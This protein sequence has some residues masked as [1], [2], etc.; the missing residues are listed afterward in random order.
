MIRHTQTL[1][2][3]FE[4]VES[5]KKGHYEHFIGPFTVPTFVA[6]TCYHW[7]YHKANQVLLKFREMWRGPTTDTRLMYLG[8]YS[9]HEFNP[10]VITVVMLNRMMV[11]LPLLANFIEYGRQQLRNGV[12]SKRYTVNPGI[13]M[14]T[15]QLITDDSR[16]D[17][18]FQRLR[19]KSINKVQ[20]MAF[21]Y[22]PP[23]LVKVYEPDPEL[24]GPPS[25]NKPLAVHKLF[26][27][28][29]YPMDYSECFK[30]YAGYWFDTSPSHSRFQ[31]YEP[32][33]NIHLKSKLAPNHFKSLGD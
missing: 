9:V 4:V 5:T 31:E 17:N 20:D 33:G 11:S 8:Y 18:I 3:P 16:N 23:T 7:Y 12:I 21:Y 29:N 1:P 22:H 27:Q 15:M 10:K 2:Q 26:I 25:P 14:D 19:Q 28:T 13:T 32:L 6:E 30:V 24:I